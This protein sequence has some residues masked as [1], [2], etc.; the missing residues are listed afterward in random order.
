MKRNPEKWE[1]E[2]AGLAAKVSLQGRMTSHGTMLSRVMPSVH[3]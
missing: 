1:R 3:H 2:G